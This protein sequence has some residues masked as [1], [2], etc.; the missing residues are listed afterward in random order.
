MF[1]P[2]PK[3]Q[4][5]QEIQ[6]WTT[7]HQN[8][9][10]QSCVLSSLSLLASREKWMANFLARKMADSNGRK[11]FSNRSCFASKIHIHV[12]LASIHFV[13][14]GMKLKACLVKRPKAPQSTRPPFMNAILCSLK[15]RMM[16]ENCHTVGETA[17]DDLPHAKS[18]VSV[19][20][21]FMFII[22]TVPLTR[23]KHAIG[24]RH[25]PK[26]NRS[27]LLRCILGANLGGKRLE[28][29]STI[30]RLVPATWLDRRT[31]FESGHSHV[32]VRGLNNCLIAWKPPVDSTLSLRNWTR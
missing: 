20:L 30:A 27:Q 8:S 22:N 6:V 13:H 9:P 3:W 4:S 12:R 23:S 10:R 18:Y 19:A 16:V 17:F 25:M 5:Q 28:R 26:A 11:V 29:L 32:R 24:M 1:S 7:R 14:G 2:L 31:F 15:S 21:S